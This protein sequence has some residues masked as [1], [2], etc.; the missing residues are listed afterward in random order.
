MTK[1]SEADRLWMIEALTEE[2]RVEHGEPAI[3]PQPKAKQP[4]SLKQEPSKNRD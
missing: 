4:R 3:K 2:E 1:K